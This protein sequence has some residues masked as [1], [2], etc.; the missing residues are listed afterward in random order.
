MKTIFTFAFVIAFTFGSGAI[1][2]PFFPPNHT[3][4]QPRYG[5][6]WGGKPTGNYGK[7]PHGPS[8]GKYPNGNYGKPNKR[9]SYRPNYG[10]NTVD[11]RSFNNFIDAMRHES[12][13]NNKLDMAR[14]Y[15]RNSNLSVEQIGRIMN[16]FTFDNNRL[17]LAKVAY[18][19]CYD[20]HNYPTLR[21]SFTFSANFNNLMRY[22]G[23]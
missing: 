23:Y 9:P 4:N 11:A 10:Y 12:F 20:K 14:F 7:K 5:S 18:E 19:T 17:E 8:V 3:S 22:V 21:P 13:D 6:N 15:A 1:A 16:E 2:Q